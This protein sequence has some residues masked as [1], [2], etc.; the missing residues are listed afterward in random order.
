MPRVTTV[1]TPSMSSP[2]RT[3]RE[4]RIVSYRRECFIRLLQR[5]VPAACPSKNNTERHTHTHTHTQWWRSWNE[6]AHSQPP[7]ALHCAPHLRWQDECGRVG[8]KV[9][10][11]QW[12][13]SSAVLISKGEN[14]RAQYLMCPP[15]PWPHQTPLREAL[16]KEKK[17]KEKRK[18]TSTRSHVLQPPAN[19]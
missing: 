6:S 10:K 18:K 9:W 8:A 19:L 3:W 1:T 2:Q 12:C 16:P 14:R 17:K 5:A 13:S 7:A 4:F 15:T 11:S